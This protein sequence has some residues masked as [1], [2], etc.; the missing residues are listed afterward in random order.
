MNM[1]KTEIIAVGTELLLGQISNTNAQWLSEKLTMFG[2]DT[3]Y[4]S[5]VGDNLSRVKATFKLAE[6]RSDLIIVTGGLGPT[7][8]DLTREAFSEMMNIPLVVHD[9]TLKELEDYFLN[10]KTTM[11]QSNEKMTKVF[12]GAKVL[13][14]NEG[15]APGLLYKTEKSTWIFLPGV[16]R[17]MKRIATDHVFPYLKTTQKYEQ[18]DSLVLNFVGI[19]ESKLEEEL[20]DIISNQTNPTIATLAKS[21]GLELRLTAKASSKEAT[22]ILLSQLKTEIL[23]KVGDFFVGTNQTTIVER[24]TKELTK[25]NST[26]SAAESLTGGMF[27][28]QMVGIPGAS[29]VCVGSI[30]CYATRIKESVLNVSSATIQSKGTVS[31]ECAIE[32][33]NGIKDL[34]DSNIAISFTGVAG[35][36]PQEGHEAGTVYIAISDKYDDVIVKCFTF[37]GNRQ[38]I[39]E[40][41]VL[42]GYEL[43]FNLLK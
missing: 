6:E 4:H 24:V 14:N 16:P 39:R 31:E 37:T 17:E 5:V 29:S 34:M 3:F 9:E 35:P 32:M 11:V 21:N 42:K 18:I 41:S 8:D 15:M 28:E 13:K 2:M 25:Q 27:T 23:K 33:V 26:I 43:L 30:V 1:K 40:K 20:R 38:T 36:G 7:D 10:Q 12:K 22:D 19:G